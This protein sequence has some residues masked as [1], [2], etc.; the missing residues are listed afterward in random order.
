[1]K[2]NRVPKRRESLF[3]FRHVKLFI[4]VDVEFREEGAE[5]SETIATTLTDDAFK[6]VIEISDANVEINSIVSHLKL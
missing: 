5:R 6:L 1:M 4:V 2:M 3:E